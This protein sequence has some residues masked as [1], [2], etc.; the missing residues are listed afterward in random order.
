[1]VSFFY[2]SLY[3]PENTVNI[4]I[5]MLDCRLGRKKITQMTNF[6]KIISICS[7]AFLDPL[8]AVF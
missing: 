1:M 6:V 2:R 8:K 7:K 4:F 5:T 3:L